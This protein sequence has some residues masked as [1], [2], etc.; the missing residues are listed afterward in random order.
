MRKNQKGFTLIELLAVII[1]LGL[2]MAIAIPSVTRYI[3]QSRKKTLVN[4]IDSFISAVT[5][6][7]NE[8][9]FGALSNQEKI[10]FIPVSNDSTKSCVELEKGGTDPFGVWQEAYVAVHYDA[11]KFS[12]DYYFTFFD[13]A[14]YGMKLTK[15]DDIA[16]SGSDIKNPSPVKHADIIS[17][18]VSAKKTSKADAANADA[19]VLSAKDCKAA[20]A[21][22]GPAA[23]S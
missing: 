3:T 22:S 11:D 7:V 20:T 2:L 14:G 19:V 1:I 16:T 5:T 18:T 15:S 21:T 12:Y 17:N 23:T 6:A 9:E 10:Y 13:D 8:Q 4:S